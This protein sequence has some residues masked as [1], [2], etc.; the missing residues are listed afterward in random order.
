MKTNAPIPPVQGEQ[1]RLSRK[2]ESLEQTV[3][4]LRARNEKLEAERQELLE[5]NWMLRRKMTLSLLI[6]GLETS[7]GV[8]KD[9]TGAAPKAPPSAEQLYHTLP[10]SFSFSVFFQI[11]ESENLDADEARRCLL[12]FFAE[13]LVAQK[14]SRLVKE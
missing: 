7:I 9:E 8:I 1:N 2:I 10:P 14:G 13:E 11:A 6:D 3:E 4:K 12:H 5:E